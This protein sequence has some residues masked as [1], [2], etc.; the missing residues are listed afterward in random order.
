MK[1]DSRHIKRTTVSFGQNIF[2]SSIS[3]V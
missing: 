2:Y 3:N 1:F